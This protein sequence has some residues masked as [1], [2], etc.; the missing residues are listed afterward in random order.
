MVIFGI[1]VQL[2]QPKT[3]SFLVIQQLAVDTERVFKQPDG[4]LAAV[5]FPVHSI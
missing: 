1:L 4:S 5:G 3:G 2:H